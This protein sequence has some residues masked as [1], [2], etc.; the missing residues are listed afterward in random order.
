MTPTNVLLLGLLTVAFWAVVA[1][2]RAYFW[3]Q[4]ALDYENKWKDRCDMH[5]LVNT[6]IKE[7]KASVFH[8]QCVAKTWENSWDFTADYLDKGGA[9]LAL[10]T[11]SAQSKYVAVIEEEPGAHLGSKEN[12]FL[13]IP[14]CGPRVPEA[15]TVQE[16][17]VV[18]TNKPFDASESSFHIV[19]LRT[20]DAIAKEAL[21]QLSPLTFVAKIHVDILNED[22]VNASKRYKFDIDNVSGKSRGAN[23][24]AMDWLLKRTKQ[25]GVKEIFGTLTQSIIN[26]AHRIRLY[27]F[28]IIKYGFV[29]NPE[30]NT[31]AKT[32]S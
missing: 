26:E 17:V 1:A 21:Q 27:N 18:L 32:I 29:Y 13:P 4:S 24:L 5:G 9:V 15:A 12:I 6:Q 8:L 16:P 3:H 2:E 11:V 22:K 7:L 14:V 23:S 31:I 19:V 28:Y 10:T 30:N 20:Q 25:E